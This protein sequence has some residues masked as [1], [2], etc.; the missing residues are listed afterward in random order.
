[1]NF[2]LGCRG[3][4]C[5]LFF[6][7]T[8]ESFI[9]VSYRCSPLGVS[10]ALRVHRSKV[11][12][13]RSSDRIKLKDCWCS[14]WVQGIIQNWI[15]DSFWFLIGWVTSQ[16]ELQRGSES[17]MSLTIQKNAWVNSNKNFL[18][19]YLITICVATGKLNT[20]CWKAPARKI[21]ECVCVCTHDA[22][23]A[24]Q[25]EDVTGQH[26]AVQRAELTLVSTLVLLR[27]VKGV[28]A[29]WDRRE[30]RGQF[31]FGLDV[32]LSSFVKCSILDVCVDLEK[33]DSRL[34][35]LSFCF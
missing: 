24:A 12:P 8:K 3:F 7:S 10:F 34:F 5:L 11:A 22:I 26:S 32:C 6:L 1:M 20:T 35:S 23:H 27:W 29:E 13:C 31:L 15:I 28:A 21:P 19:M 14:D 18:Y 30:V 16:Y 17:I 4:F 25:W 9:K 33:R 2:M